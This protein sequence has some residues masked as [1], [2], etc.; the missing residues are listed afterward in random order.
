MSEFIHGT[1]V[2]HAARALCQWY[3]DH[4]IQRLGMTEWDI[5]DYVDD[6]FQHHVQTVLTVNAANAEFEEEG[7]N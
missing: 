7:S 2:E 4:K 1:S 6:H 5:R 3:L